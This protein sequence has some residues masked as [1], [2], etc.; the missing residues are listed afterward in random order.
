[1]QPFETIRYLGEGAE[2]ETIM[3]ARI[4]TGRPESLSIKITSNVGSATAT[5]RPTAGEILRPVSELTPSQFVLLERQLGGTFANE[6]VIPLTSI[7]PFTW[8]VSVH[9]PFS[10]T[11]ILFS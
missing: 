3:S 9:I 4:I 5:M 6:A 1:M 2:V 8:Q 7:K 11:K 10:R